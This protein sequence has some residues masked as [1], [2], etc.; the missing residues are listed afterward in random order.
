M[1]RSFDLDVLS[2]ILP[3]F[4]IQS[5]SLCGVLLAAQCKGAPPP[6]KR[7]F[8]VFPQDWRPR[9]QPGDIRWPGRGAWSLQ[10]SCSHKPTHTAHSANQSTQG[11]WS[12]IRCRHATCQH[13][14]FSVSVRG[15]CGVCGV[16]G[17]LMH[18]SLCVS[19]L[20][21]AHPADLLSEL[22][23]TLLC[24]TDSSRRVGGPNAKY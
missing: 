6:D 15:V 16:C 24:P 13:C 19:C 11:Q 21:W 20:H 14:D 18:G 7:F 1:I 22:S 3:G 5:K 9:G 10:P 23:I 4:R 8:M 17:A 2:E 12:W